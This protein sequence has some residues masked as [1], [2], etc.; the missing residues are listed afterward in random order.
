MRVRLVRNKLLLP[1]K[2]IPYAIFEPE[3]AIEL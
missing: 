1:F 3:H 2:K